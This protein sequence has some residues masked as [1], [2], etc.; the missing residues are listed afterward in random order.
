MWRYRKHPDHGAGGSTA[1]VGVSQRHRRKGSSKHTLVNLRCCVLV[2][3]G[4]NDRNDTAHSDISCVECLE[5]VTKLSKDD[6]CVVTRQGSR[7]FLSLD[8]G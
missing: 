6:F 7:D 5:G 4:K 1:L 2:G 8:W 3:P